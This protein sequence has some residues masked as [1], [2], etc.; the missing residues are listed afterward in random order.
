MTLSEW[1]AQKQ[2][3]RIDEVITFFDRVAG[4]A[5][6]LSL[7]HSTVRSWQVRGRISRSG[8]QLLQKKTKGR[9][10]VSYMLP[11]AEEWYREKGGN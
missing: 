4:L 10:P 8:A 5:D 6:M 1:T 11:L 2:K 7:P 3:E 9:F